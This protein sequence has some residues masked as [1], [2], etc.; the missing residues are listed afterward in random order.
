MFSNAEAARL[1]P[2]MYVGSTGPRGIKQL[3]SEVLSNSVD[4]ALA[5]SVTEL[6]VRVEGDGGFTII[7]DGPG[8][9]VMPGDDGVPFLTRVV[10]TWRDTP[11]ADGHEPHVHLGFGLGLPVVCALSDRLEIITTRAGQTWRQ[12][13]AAGHTV[14]GLERTD[15]AGSAGTS[16]SFR[17]DPAIFEPPRRLDLGTLDRLLE[18]LSALVPGLVTELEVERYRRPPQEPAAL[19]GNGG[20][21][22]LR[23]GD[24]QDAMVIAFSVGGVERAVTGRWFLNLQELIGTKPLAKVLS[25]AFGTV[26]GAHRSGV[27]V[28]VSAM[29]LSPEFSGPTRTECDDPHLKKLIR[30][31]VKEGLPVLLAADPELRSALLVT[32][33]AP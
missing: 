23:G 18:D 22:Q 33:N 5:G 13:F 26:L 28:V 8:I 2:G 6:R 24:G 27:Q 32:Q 25:D 12:R 19:L 16:V 10:T 20:S 9:D 30:R 11:T 31:T 21:W 29:M 15:D 17:P 1:R 3:V 14:T 7:D 4:Q